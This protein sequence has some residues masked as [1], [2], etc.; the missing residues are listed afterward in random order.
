MTLQQIIVREQE[1]RTESG[2]FG[3]AACKEFIRDFEVELRG[4]SLYAVLGEY[5][6]QANADPFFNKR[7]VLACW[8][9]INE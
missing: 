5:V 6:E 7:M 1:R 8:E 2:A 3:I 4:K 9:L